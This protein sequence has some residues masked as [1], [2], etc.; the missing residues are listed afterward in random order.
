[1]SQQQ[2]DYFDPREFT[3]HEINREEMSGFLEKLFQHTSNHHAGFN[4]KLKDIPQGYKFFV[5]VPLDEISKNY[6]N[7]IIYI[8]L[9]KGRK[10]FLQWEFVFPGT[11]R[12]L[13]N[14]R[15]NPFRALKIQQSQFVMIDAAQVQRLQ[16]NKQMTLPSM[17]QKITKLEKQ[18]ENL[19]RKLDL[20]VAPSRSSSRSSSHAEQQLI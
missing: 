10:E 7:Y 6:E 8:V 12:M 2:Q 5:Y 19:H 16:K 4:L 11:S 1:M 3:K 14:F 13:H 18:V 20:L 15:T 9:Y 17:F